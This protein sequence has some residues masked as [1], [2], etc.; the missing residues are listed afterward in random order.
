MYVDSFTSLNYAEGGNGT[1]MAT[2]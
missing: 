2:L 1:D